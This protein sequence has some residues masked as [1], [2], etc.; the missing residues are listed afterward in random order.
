MFDMLI[1]MAKLIVRLSTPS[2]Y[3]MIL[4]EKELYDKFNEEMRR[5]FGEGWKIGGVK[6]NEG[7]GGGVE[8]KHSKH[9]DPLDKVSQAI[10]LLKE[11]SEEV[12]C[13][14]V[15]DVIDEALLTVS[16]RLAK[17]LDI[18]S[19]KDIIDAVKEVVEEEEIDDFDSL[20]EEEKKKVLKKVREKVIR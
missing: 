15:R 10:K 9:E 5:K 14:V 11:A 3:D 8:I 12:E 19:K 4:K 2:T 7:A 13:P 1:D 16:E 6:S 18:I 20:P 17:R